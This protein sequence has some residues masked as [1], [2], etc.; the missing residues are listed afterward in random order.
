MKK[1][2]SF[3]LALTLVAALLVM[4]ALA[5]ESAVYSYGT[6]S[7][8]N[9]PI[10]RTGAERVYT[11]TN[12]SSCGYASYSHSHAYYR[13][14]YTYSCDGLCTRYNE[15]GSSTTR[16]FCGASNMWLGIDIVDQIM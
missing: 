8:C 15:W 14:Y 1:F 7:E 9:G 4:P 13:M 2:V 6:C 16:T 3:A 5:A 10:T 12:V 11:S